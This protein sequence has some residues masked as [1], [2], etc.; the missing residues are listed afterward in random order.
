VYDN[1]PF[2][3]AMDH[4]PHNLNKAPKYKYTPIRKMSIIAILVEEKASNMNECSPIRIW[5]NKMWYVYS[6][7]YPGFKITE[8]RGTWV[9]QSFKHPTLDFGS[10]HDLRVMRSSPTWSPTW[11]SILGVEPCLRFSL[12]LPLPPHLSN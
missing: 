1:I 6:T 10:G 7:D 12:P 9:A 4:H 8:I 5:L 3:T 2:N 11:G